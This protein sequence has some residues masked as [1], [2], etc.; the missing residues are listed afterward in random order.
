MVRGTATFMYRTLLRNMMDATH[1]ASAQ[2][3]LS[4]LTKENMTSSST[5]I[6]ELAACTGCGY[7]RKTSGLLRHPNWRRPSRSYQV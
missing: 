6:H 4:I 7:Q 5:F 1:L 2:R 3:N